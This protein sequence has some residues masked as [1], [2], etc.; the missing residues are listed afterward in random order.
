MPQMNKRKES[1]NSRTQQLE[2]ELLGNIEEHAKTAE[3]GRRNIQNQTFSDMRVNSQQ[4]A[5]FIKQGKHLRHPES[6]LHRFDAV[7]DTTQNVRHQ[8]EEALVDHTAR[9]ELPEEYKY[10]GDDDGM[11]VDQVGIANVARRN[12]QASQSLLQRL[13]AGSL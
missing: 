9:Y 2:K 13:H 12:F 6:V 8:W 11:V 4:K 10:K 1:S 5:L 7:K 3:T